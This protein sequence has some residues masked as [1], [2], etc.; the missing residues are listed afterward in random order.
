MTQWNPKKAT[1]RDVLPAQ[2]SVVTP[3]QAALT[4]EL[5]EMDEAAL[6]QFVDDLINYDYFLSAPIPA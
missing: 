5:S 3:S 1:A 2:P 4:E 6:D